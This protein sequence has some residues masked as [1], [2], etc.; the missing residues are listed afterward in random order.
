MDYYSKIL[1]LSSKALIPELDAIDALKPYLQDYID[2]EGKIEVRAKKYIHKVASQKSNFVQSML[3]QY[4]LKSP[5]GYAIMSLAECLQRVPDK[6]TAYALIN[7]KISGVNWKSGNG[8][9]TSLV[10]KAV[11]HSLNLAA[12]M[13]GN[14]IVLTALKTAFGQ[15]GKEF[16]LG[17]TI[18]EAAKNGEKLKAEGYH[19]SYDMLGEG[20]RTHKQAE[21]YFK[22]YLNAINS[23]ANKHSDIFANDSISIKISALHPK[24]E[25][26]K[27]E[28]LRAE[29]LPKLRELII[30]AKARNIAV[31]IDAEEARRLDLS[32]LLFSELFF[33]DEVRYSGFGLAVQAYQKRSLS[34]LKYLQELAE[35]KSAKIPVRL[36]KG[37]YWDAE[38]KKAQADGLADFYVYTK[39]EHTDLS[40][41]AAARFMLKNAANFYPQF[42][43][44]NIY[45]IAAIIETAG[46]K[47]EFQRLQGMGKEVYDYLIAEEKLKCRVYAPVGE[48]ADLLAYL[49]RRLLE[50]GANNSFVHQLASANIEA[51]VKSPFK[52]LDRVTVN[53]R[54]PQ[55]AEIYGKRKNSK[56][57]DFGSLEQIEALK[58]VIVA[59][60]E[61]PEV[62]EFKEGID[63]KAFEEWNSIGVYKRAEILKTIADE[64]E[65]NSDELI[66]IL[67]YEAKK[68]P[69]DAIGEIREA[70]DFCRFYAN[71]AEQILEPKTTAGITGEQNIYSHQGRGAFVCIS[72]WNFPLSIF[73]GQ[74]VAALVTGNLVFAKP[75]EQTPNIAKFA[76]NLMHK[77]GVPKQVLKLEIGA[78]E[79][80]G[81]KLVASP[82]IAGVCFTGST[83][84]ARKINTSLTQNNK[85]IVPLIAETGGQN[86]MIVD[87]TALLEQTVDDVVISAFGSA[88]QRCSALRVLYLQNDIA[89]EF[90][91]LLK[92][93]VAAIKIG[94]S[95]DVSVDISEVIDDE[96]KKILDEHIFKMQREAVFICKAEK[97]IEG[98]S[99]VPPHVFEIRSI[100]EL[101]REVFGPIL[102]IIRFKSNEVDK[103]I[104][105]INSTGY[106]LTCGV[107]TR[108]ESRANYIAEKIKAGNVYIN[109]SMIGAV[110]ESQPFG[111]MGLSGTGPK[112][113]GEDY[114]RRFCTEKIITTNKTAFGGNLELL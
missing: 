63:Q 75:A 28:Q 26:N 58:A 12:K 23:K 15:M 87:S 40:Y 83:E 25:L 27:Y 104:A 78:G 80:I 103:V 105:D 57:T 81:A 34:V 68:T 36:V 99:F 2:A 113:G 108:I 65:K 114:L 49:I 44:H 59:E 92:G 37:A 62:A 85:N 39:K 9:T 51:L 29:L 54:I 91:E 55:S 76:I 64:F 66:K 96:A 109:R 17:E 53:S 42:A 19:I 107:Q 10:A 102:H 93:A 18:Q 97:E 41:L 38:I 20:A 43:T 6:D 95:N 3:G 5:Q 35:L 79:K 106:G 89:D 82:D 69:Q 1:E 90:I 100:S 4:P 67:V 86:C 84:V 77:A 13:G 73:T 52:N 98:G 11:S 111:G 7:D 48:Q 101:P 22:S 47:P 45:T 88:G 72:P 24:Y 56:G 71:A 31:V 74:V 61:V 70:I 112:A 110:V 30:A 94:K 50:N 16:I 32:L 33:D 60:A 8:G 21:T 14:L 46:A